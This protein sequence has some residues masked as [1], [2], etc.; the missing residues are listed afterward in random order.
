MVVGSQE[1]AAASSITMDQTIYHCIVLHNF[2]AIT[3][4]YCGDTFFMIY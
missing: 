2:I 3:M 4:G 1:R